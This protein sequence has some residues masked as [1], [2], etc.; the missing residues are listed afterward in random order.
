MKLRILLSIGL[1]SAT[2]ASQAPAQGALS[3]AQVR[4]ELAEARRTGELLGAGELGLPLNQL[5]PHSYPSVPQAAGK[6]RDQVK[7]ELAEALRTGDI[8]AGE[9]SYR[10]NEIHPNLYPPVV[11]AQGKTREEA[12]QELADALASGDI[13]AGGE[14]GLKRNE[15]F[16]GYAIPMGD[17]FA[18]RR[19]AWDA[20][21]GLFSL[22]R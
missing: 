9:S 20:H 4:A 3:V 16:P 11:M 15:L 13:I 10:L 22:R 14:L 19:P 2:V 6:S 1:L 17:T 21:K 8:V 12:K 5:H 18:G 7:A